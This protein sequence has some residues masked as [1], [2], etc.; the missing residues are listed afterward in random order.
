[1]NTDDTNDA[2]K[3]Q[4]DF[5]DLKKSGVEIIGEDTG[6][7]ST[8]SFSS[9]S[10]DKL[11]REFEAEM[12]TDPKTEVGHS[13]LSAS[14]AHLKQTK[15]KIAMEEK[16]LEQET[17][18]EIEALKKTKATIEEKITHIKKLEQAHN[19]IDL[20]IKKIEDL[21]LQKKQIEED[22]KKFDQVQ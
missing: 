12:N 21:E 7:P 9:A 13:D 6:Q 17:S 2:T 5:A 4:T 10:A 16:A 15:D 3:Q 18:R 8:E 1:M 14:L 11:K 19:E 20:K 22:I